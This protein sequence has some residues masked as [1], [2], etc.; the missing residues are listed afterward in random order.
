M[1][2]LAEELD[3]EK[4]GREEAIKTA[5]EK[6]KTADSAEKRASAAE[7]S[8]ASAKKRSVELVAQHNETEVKMAEAASLNSTLSEEVADLRAGG[9]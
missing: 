6:T 9:P 1:K 5:K 8:R 3:W 7:K 4:A 2:D